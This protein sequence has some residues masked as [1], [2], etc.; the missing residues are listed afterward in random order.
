MKKIFS[1]LSTSILTLGIFTSSVMRSFSEDPGLNQLKSKYIVLMDYNSGQ[2]IY[3][4]NADE[5]MYPASTT[6]VWTAFC[7]L[8]KEKD[9]NRKIG[10]KD[11]P[12]VEGSSMYLENGESFTVKELLEALLIQSAND[13]AYILSREYGGGDPKKFIDFMNEEA[14]KYGAKHTHFNN[15]H[16]LPDTNHYTTA[17][18]MT[19]LSR[20][21]YGNE[22]IKKIVSTK[23]VSFKK[24]ETCKLDRV[25]INSN[26]F[27]TSPDNMEYKGREV[28]IELPMIEGMKT[29]YTDDAG[30]CLVS[31]ASKDGTR[32]VAGVF[33]APG[34][35][36][37]HDSRYVLDYG[38]DNF[39]ST[40]IVDKK[41]FSGE[42]SVRF[43]SPGK[44]KYTLA[45]TYNVIS[46]KGETINKSDYT[47][48]VNFDNLDM[49][50]K[51]GDIIGTLNIYNKGNIESTIGLVAENDSS[52]F[53]ND[54]TAKISSIFS[55]TGSKVKDKV[56]SVKNKT[57]K[58]SGILKNT[59]VGDLEKSNFYAFL[60]KNISQRTDVLPPKVIIFGI[61]ILIIIVALILI[62]GI[63]KDSVKKRKQKRN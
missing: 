37:Y 13:V 59:F 20:V 46:K 34:G 12:Q 21:A 15:A 33:S 29:G 60:E 19:N 4:K 38:F 51:K 48:K 9:L 14:K 43:A 55:K 57:S 47:T 17:A 16:G 1:I 22:T 40:P 52:Y 54:I 42:K 41:S 3:K 25:L 63:I 28:P 23:S 18:D 7:V 8:L 50:V 27:L 49:P 31:V 56:D 36:L 61:P 53:W 45:N 24:S 58:S 11:M 6:K 26:K 62:I 10:I 2:V 35:S 30:N 39:T 32:L 44:I 5:K